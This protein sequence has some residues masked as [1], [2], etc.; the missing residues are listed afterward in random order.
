MYEKHNTPNQE[1][2]GLMWTSVLVFEPL[3]PLSIPTA[4]DVRRAEMREMLF[5]L[6]ARVGS[7]LWVNT[8]HSSAS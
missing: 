8:H 2:E 4:N 7:Q 3:R 5:Y 6:E 1:V